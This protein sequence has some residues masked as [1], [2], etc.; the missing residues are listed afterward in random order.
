HTA[1]EQRRVAREEYFD[2]GKIVWKWQ[3]EV[4][5]ADLDARNRKRFHNGSKDLIAER[6]EQAVA[7]VASHHFHHLAVHRLVVDGVLQRIAAT[8][9]GEIAVDGGGDL[10]LL[11]YI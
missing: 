10:D 7:F 5:Q 8:R 3:V 2:V 11:R 9:G 4:A 6:F 1:L